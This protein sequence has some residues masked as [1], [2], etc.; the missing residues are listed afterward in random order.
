MRTTSEAK[1]VGMLNTPETGKTQ[2]PLVEAMRLVREAREDAFDTPGLYY[3]SGV[4]L[5]ALDDAIKRLAEV[6]YAL[7]WKRPA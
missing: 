5:G 7:E 6:S 3:A 2:G 4:V 1:I